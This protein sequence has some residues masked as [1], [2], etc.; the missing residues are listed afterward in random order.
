MAQ[1]NLSTVVA[2]EFLRTVRKRGF[3]IAILAVPVVIAIIF[4][5][6]FTSNTSISDSSAAQAEAEIAFTYTDASGTIPEELADAYG[7]QPADATP[8]PTD[9]TH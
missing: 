2:F 4:A 1:H 6:S 3:W 8:R 9:L 5:L 7:G